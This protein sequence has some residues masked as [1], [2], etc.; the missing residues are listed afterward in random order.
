MTAICRDHIAELK[1][2]LLFRRLRQL[3]R[4]YSSISFND[5]V[6]TIGF[7]GSDDRARGLL[8]DLQWPVTEDNFVEPKNSS[9]LD[10]LMIELINSDY[11]VEVI[12]NTKPSASI[13]G[14]P[15]DAIKRLA[16]YANKLDQKT[17]VATADPVQRFT[18]MY[19]PVFYQPK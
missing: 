13:E 5:F 3:M 11:G 4:V 2:R 1:S 10:S 12:S 6:K 9:R 15:I 16:E 7:S 14:L 17:E 8:Q 18:P 19:E